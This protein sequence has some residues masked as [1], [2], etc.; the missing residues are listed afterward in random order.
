[1]SITETGHKHKN[2]VI[3]ISVFS[4]FKAK[5]YSLKFLR[6]DIYIV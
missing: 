3:D 4:T 1:M 5:T 2:E 6:F